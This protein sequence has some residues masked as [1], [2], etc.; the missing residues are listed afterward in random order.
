MIVVVVERIMV[1]P[2]KAYDAKR[3]YRLIQDRSAMLRRNRR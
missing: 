3:I 2:D 1:L